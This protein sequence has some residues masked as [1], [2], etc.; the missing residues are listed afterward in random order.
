MKFGRSMLI[1]VAGLLVLVVGIVIY[2]YTNLDAIVKREIERYGSQLTGTTVWVESVS[3]S[4]TDGKGTL[5]G[6]HIANPSGFSSQD[7]FSLEQITLD[8]VPS[9]ITGNPV[10]VEN[11]IVGSPVIHYEINDRGSSNIGTIKSNMGKGDSSSSSSSSSDETRLSVQRFKF[12]GGE[13]KA[14]ASLLLGK[15]VEVK[16]PELSMSNMNGSPGKVGKEI[17]SAYIAKI[18][19]VVATSQIE[20]GVESKASGVI[21]DAVPGEAGEALG[22]LI[23][24]VFDK[25][26]GQGDDK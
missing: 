3:I 21:K 16:L 13:L 5:R 14:N 10:V 8:I 18:L 15:G 1:G 17:L 2:L 20:K 25:L 7:A 6:L 26:P 23:D 24:G 19:F 9:T 11:V 22:G 12:E 4:P